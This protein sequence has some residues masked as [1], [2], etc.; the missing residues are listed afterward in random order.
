MRENIDEIDRRILGVL[1]RDASLS[2]DDISDRVNLS[3]NACWRRIR[4][5]EESGVIRGRV[6]LADA[7]KVGCPLEVMVMV[8]TSAHEAGWMAGFQKAIRAMPEIT[9]AYRMSGD[10]DYLL[11]VRVAD[12]PAYDHFYKRLIAQVN[13]SDISASFVMEEIKDTTALPL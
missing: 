5:M 7:R 3:R 9:G 4:L 10:L 11:R 13:L 8:R 2:V 12:V 1:Q 6:V